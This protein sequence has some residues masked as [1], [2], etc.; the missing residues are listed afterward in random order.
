[1]RKRIKWISLILSVGFLC[2]YPLDQPVW[3]QQKT[4]PPG[5]FVQWLPITDSERQMKGP[6]VDKD[7]GAEILLWRVHVVDEYLSVGLQSG[8]FITTCG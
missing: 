8:C 1:M 2:F 7:A 5:E 3:A 4:P 6:L